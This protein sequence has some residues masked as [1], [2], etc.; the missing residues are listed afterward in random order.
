MHRNIRTAY[1]HSLF[2]FPHFTS[3]VHDCDDRAA[4]DGSPIERVGFL[5]E[6]FLSVEDYR[7]HVS[8]KSAWKWIRSSDVGLSSF[9]RVCLY[10]CLVFCVQR[11]SVE[12]L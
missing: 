3:I 1:F 10:M 7:Q 6:D 8:G 5:L 9:G 12:F 11:F 2:C 4:V